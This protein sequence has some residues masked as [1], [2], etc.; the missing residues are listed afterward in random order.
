M[1]S[2]GSE[3]PPRWNSAEEKRRINEALWKQS[4][5]RTHRL[6]CECPDWTSHIKIWHTTTTG[7]GHGGG[8]EGDTGTTG[9]GIEN[10]FHSDGSVAENG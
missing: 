2:C 10:G 5:S 1:D 3:S 6:W 7:G 4:C 8:K 9:G